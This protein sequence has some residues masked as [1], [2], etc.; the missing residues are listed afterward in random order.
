MDLFHVFKIVQMLSNRAKHHIFFILGCGVI[1]IVE[2]G[3]YLGTSVTAAD[4]TGV[5]I[6]EAKILSEIKHDNIVDLLGD[7]EKPVS[8]MMELC[9]FDFEPFN[10]DQNVSSLDQFL[11]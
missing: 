5:F 7:C 6:K 3:Y 10:T 2:K 9:E 1:L 4:V 8:S 11:S